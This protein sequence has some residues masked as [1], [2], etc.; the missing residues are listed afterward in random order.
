MVIISTSDTATLIANDA[1]GPYRKPPITI[2]TSFGSYFRKLTIGMRH[3]A[4]T[5]YATA[6]RSPSTASRRVLSFSF[7]AV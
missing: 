1:S 6:H 4:T 5:T 2:T 3:T 7:I